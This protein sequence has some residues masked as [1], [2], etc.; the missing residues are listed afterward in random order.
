MMIVKVVVVVKAAKV[1]VVVK[2][3]MIQSRREF[4]HESYRLQRGCES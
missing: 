1:V 4:P 2:V 3:V